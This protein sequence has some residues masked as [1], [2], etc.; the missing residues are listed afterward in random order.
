[1]G[2]WPNSAEF[3]LSRLRGRAGVGVSPDNAL[4][5]T[6]PIN[7]CADVVPFDESLCGG[8]PTPTLPRKQERGRRTAAFS[9]RGSPEFFHFVHPPKSRGR[10]ECR[11][12][13]ATRGL[14]CNV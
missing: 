2:Q 10:W 13:A 3:P 7:L 12:T 11:V 6:I 1:M 8:T 4:I 9:Q 5:I 14:V